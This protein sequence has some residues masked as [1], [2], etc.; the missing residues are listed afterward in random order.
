MYR[1][2]S[3]YGPVASTAWGLHAIRFADDK[4]SV[5]QL[6]LVVPCWGSPEPQVLATLQQSLTLPMPVEVLALVAPGAGDALGRQ[7]SSQMGDAGQALR[8]V[9]VG[10][11]HPTSADVL[12]AVQTAFFTVLRPGDA[13]AGQVLLERMQ[14]MV[15]CP[16]VVLASCRPVLRRDGAVTTADPAPGEAELPAPWGRP[17]FEEHQIVSGREL[18]RAMTVS[19]ANVLG[20]TSAVLVRTAYVGDPVRWQPPAGADDGW[21]LALWLEVMAR[22]RVFYYAGPGV[23]VRPESRAERTAELRA[24]PACI[25]ASAGRG[26]LPER[27]DVARAF[28]AH[29]LNGVAGLLSETPG[30]GLQGAGGGVAGENGIDAGQVAEEADIVREITAHWEEALTAYRPPIPLRSGGSRSNGDAPPA[31]VARTQP[32]AAFGSA[33]ARRFVVTAPP[34]N[35]GSSGIVVLHLLCELLN[36]LGCEAS[37]APMDPASAAL[38]VPGSGWVSG[39]LSGADAHKAMADGAVVIYPEIVHGNPYGTDRVVRWL[40]NRPGYIHGNDLGESPTD[41]LVV[42]HRRFSA[43]LPVLWLPPV[44]PDV[45][46]PKSAPG[47]GDVVWAGKEPLPDDFD[48]VGKTFITKDWPADKHDLADL[49]RSA[50]VLY[51]PDW[52]TAMG[53]EAL[54]CGTPVVLVGEGGRWTREELHDQELHFPGD[55][56]AAAKISAMGTHA[57]YL[58]RIDQGVADVESFV[59][60]VEE[61]FARPV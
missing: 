56:L 27:G 29:L 16:D 6:S 55:D 61:H 10:S 3:G 32:T 24:W 7:L 15:G 42:F 35:P 33:G 51:T 60:L 19:A 45:F 18:A 23:I 21:H 47:S 4:G 37:M 11:G 40:L 17:L 57:D 36:R 41:L 44:D 30:D 52:C 9:E 25:T 5:T 12:G 34:Y 20:P 28:G 48:V 2:A 31:W 22:G 54:L 43:E 26:L 53:R 58:K 38:P 46:F 59:G 49:L 50:D 13:C 8:I 14:V 1:Q 39:F